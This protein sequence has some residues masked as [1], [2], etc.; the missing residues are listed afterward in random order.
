MFVYPSNHPFRGNDFFCIEEKKDYLRNKTKQDRLQVLAVLCI[1]S[2]ITFS[3]DYDLIVNKFVECKKRKK[4]CSA[5]GP[6][7]LMVVDCM[8]I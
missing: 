7:L 1:E 8:S 6:L 4:S 5:L 3:L 2:E